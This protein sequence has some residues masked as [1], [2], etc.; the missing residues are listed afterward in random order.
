VVRL[1]LLLGPRRRRQNEKGKR[2]KEKW[3]PAMAV[4]GRHRL[5]PAV[6]FISHFTLFL[7]HSLPPPQPADREERQRRAQEPRVPLLRQR[8]RLVAH[9]AAGERFE[10]RAEE[11]AEPRRVP[12]G[13]DVLAAGLGRDLLE[14]PLLELRAD[15]LLAEHE[16]GR[17]VRVAD[18]DGVDRD[19]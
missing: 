17:G 15:Q 19:A 13:G 9:L 11:L 12:A 16:G 5:S 1:R 2:K 3:K 18:P 7:L 6:S 14:R 8:D 10:V 4:S